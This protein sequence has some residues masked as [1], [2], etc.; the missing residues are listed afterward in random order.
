[1]PHPQKIRGKEIMANMETAV[2]DPTKK[3][4]CIDLTF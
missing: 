2:N 4:G 1:M 3:E